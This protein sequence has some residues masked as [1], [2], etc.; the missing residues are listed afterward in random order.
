MNEMPDKNQKKCFQ[1]DTLN[2][3]FVFCFGGY[4]DNSYFSGQC[5]AIKMILQ[6]ETIQSDLNNHWENYDHYIT[7][8]YFLAKHEILPYCWL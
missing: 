4:T 2:R 3:K 1:N 5:R 6:V 8:K 7:F